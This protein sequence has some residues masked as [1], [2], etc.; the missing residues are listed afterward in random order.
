MDL[1]LFRFLYSQ[2]DSPVAGKA[3]RQDQFRDH[4]GNYTC[5]HAALCRISN[6][7]RRV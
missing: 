2:L 1:G 3:I 5:S 6:I 4:L 7:W